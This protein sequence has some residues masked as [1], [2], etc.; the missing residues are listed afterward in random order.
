VQ[1]P[2]AILKAC[3]VLLIFA[4][5][6]GFTLCDCELSK[7]FS[8]GYLPLAGFELLLG[9]SEHSPIAFLCMNE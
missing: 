6:S 2:A 7:L 3:P 9:F 8:Q 4:I 5:A 1:T